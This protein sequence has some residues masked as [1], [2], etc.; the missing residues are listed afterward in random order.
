M[1]TVIPAPV[2]QAFSPGS[3]F[4]SSIHELELV[5]LIRNLFYHARARR[6]PIVAKWNRN[7]R[8]L[9]NQVYSPNRPAWLPSPELPEIFP[10]ISAVIGWLTD[11]RPTLDAIPFAEPHSSFYA[12]YSQLSHD[13][14]VAI[15]AA[16]E[17]HEYDA[18]VY[19]VGWDAYT[20]GTGI[21]K[22]GW[23]NTLI[24]GL[25]DAVLTRVDPFS[26]Y[27]DPDATSMRDA[28]YFI[29]ARTMSIQEMDRRWPGSGRKFYVEGFTEDIDKAPS[30]DWVASFARANPGAIPPATSPSFG[31]P[32]ASRVHATESP[33]VTILEAW[34]RKHH[35]TTDSETG[36]TRTHDN[37]RVVVIAGNH[38]LMDED[39]SDVFAHGQ[40]PYERYV[41]D[42]LGEF[43]GPAM[44]EML[45]PPQLSINHLLSSLE[46][47]IDLT[48]NPV[49]KESTRAG[50][51]RT[52]ITNKAGTRLPVNENAT[53][54][55]LEPPQLNAGIVIEMVRLYINEM[56][57]I[58]GLS[59]IN[60]GMM[61]GGRN[62]QGT[63]EAVQEAGFV[64]IRK[65]LRHLEWALRA[66][67]DKLAA[68]IT[69]NYTA[70]R[71]I[72]IVGPTAERSSK[73]LLGRHFYLPT[74][75]GQVPMRTRIQI[76]AGSQMATARQTRIAEA[77]TL[78]AMGAIDH[79]AVLEV[80]EFPGRRAVLDRITNLQAAGAWNPPGARERANRTS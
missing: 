7:Y 4:P 2:A 66:C 35:S 6:R 54:E 24:G 23:D 17:S 44:V 80:H 15:E 33:G 30:Q 78:F 9:R 46:H 50:I 61:P 32:G 62:A 3:T 55:W 13:L 70:P 38:V 63:I 25:G 65:S 36:I 64:R 69:E 57:R 20:Y 28:N 58:S 45:I 14:E 51:S 72:S 27:P 22:T 74:P 31:P 12:F 1:A 75:E 10:I 18:E 53:A 43:W 8:I 26:F 67:G 73:A 5:G 34:L 37:W 79:E 77:D 21:F 76:R 48:G 19:K 40:H 49:F 29:E 60:Q 59:A 41:T 68:L 11:Q 71:M 47:N 52:K 16:W 42:D 39:A 56:E